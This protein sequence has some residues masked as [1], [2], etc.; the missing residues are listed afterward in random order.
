VCYKE[1]FHLNDLGAPM[2]CHP[3]L[4]SHSLTRVVPSCGVCADEST[5]AV[6]AALK[7]GG[8]VMS[9]KPEAQPGTVET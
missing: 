2:R 7:V 5:R 6:I 4:R 9:F 1:Y 3:I 8:F